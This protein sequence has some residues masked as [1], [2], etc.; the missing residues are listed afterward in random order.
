MCVVSKN[1][2]PEIVEYN[3]PIC[4]EEIIGYEYDPNL[5]H[6]QQCRE[7]KEN[8]GNRTPKE[9]AEYLEMKWEEAKNE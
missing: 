5:A 8:G 7:L 6:A 9:I 2:M 4:G 3:C 1:Y